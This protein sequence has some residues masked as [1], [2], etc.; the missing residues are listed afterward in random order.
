V[1]VPNPSWSY[2]RSPN[3]KP[4]DDQGGYVIAYALEDM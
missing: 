2:P 3:D 4:S 1:T